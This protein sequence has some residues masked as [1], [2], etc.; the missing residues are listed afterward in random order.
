MR[1]DNSHS[2]GVGYTKVDS[3]TRAGNKLATGSLLNQDKQLNLKENSRS[4][5]TILKETGDNPKNGRKG[6]HTLHQVTLL[7]PEHVCHC[8]NTAAETWTSASHTQTKDQN[9]HFTKAQRAS[10]QK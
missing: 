3:F 7:H 6:F 8:H 1:A 4:G 2:G 5:Q 10:I 9:R